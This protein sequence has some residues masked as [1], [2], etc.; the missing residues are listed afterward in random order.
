MP[1]FYFFDLLLYRVRNNFYALFNLPFL[2]HS[3]SF[4]SVDIPHTQSSIWAFSKWLLSYLTFTPSLATLSVLAFLW[5]YRLLS[6]F[7]IL[8]FSQLSEN[9]WNEIPI[10]L[11]AYLS[12]PLRASSFKSNWSVSF[13]EHVS[14]QFSISVHRTSLP[15]DLTK[16][17]HTHDA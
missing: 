10:P 17:H 2:F 7:H 5:P 16:A 3:L 1:H 9:C 14:R 13:S 8:M 6:L 11:W 12:G 15:L 4:T